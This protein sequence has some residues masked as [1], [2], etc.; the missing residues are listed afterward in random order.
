MINKRES[1]ERKR[2]EGHKKYTTGREE[3][4]IKADVMKIVFPVIDNFR[5]ALKQ[6]E[7]LNLDQVPTLVAN[8]IVDRI[9]AHIVKKYVEKGK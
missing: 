1:W 5:K 9:V 6:K 7:D 4:R 8:E 2:A 3:K